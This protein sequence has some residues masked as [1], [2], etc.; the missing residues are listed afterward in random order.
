VRERE[1][2]RER[3]KER[4]RVRASQYVCVHVCVCVYVCMRESETPRW[5]QRQRGWLDVTKAARD[6]VDYD[7]FVPPKLWG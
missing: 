3:K 2:E 5:Q 4:E 7:C 1:R 6:T